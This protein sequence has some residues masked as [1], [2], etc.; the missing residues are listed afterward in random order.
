[1]GP[2]DRLD[3]RPGLSGR[4]LGC[5]HGQVDE[6]AVGALIGRGEGGSRGQVDLPGGDAGGDRFRTADRSDGGVPGGDQNGQDGRALGAR[7]A[8]N[9]VN[10]DAIS[11]YDAPVTSTALLG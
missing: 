8:M 3:D 11:A 9:D 1:M 10:H 7:G 6:D 4:R 5:T 2:G